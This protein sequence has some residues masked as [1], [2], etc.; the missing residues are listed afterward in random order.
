MDSLGCVTGNG[1]L[2]TCAMVSAGDHT[3]A[4]D[5]KF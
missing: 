5:I 2:Y 1:T 3:F 4:A